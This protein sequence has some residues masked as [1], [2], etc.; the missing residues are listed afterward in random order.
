MSRRPALVTLVGSA[1]LVSLGCSAATTTFSSLSNQGIVPVSSENPFMGSNLFLA[2]EM[3]ES[4]YLYNFLK[5]RGA[6]Q[7][8]ALQGEKEEE[9]QMTMYYSGTHESYSATP[10]I[11]PTL[12]NREWII[13]GPYAL[14]RSVYREVSQL[15][16]SDGAVFEIFGRREVL[17]GPVRAAET[18]VIAPAFVPTPKPKLHR[19]KRK[20]KTEQPATTE[21]TTTASSGDAPSNFDQEALAEARAKGQGSSSSA[22]PNANSAP[23]A[24]RAKATA[25]PLVVFERIKPQVLPGA[26][27]S[28][29]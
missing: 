11:D 22:T 17:G 27:P 10:Q 12:R 20:A 19:K 16:P 4:S 2:K 14:D 28:T 21:S 29:R 24:P 7:A 6:P 15:P 26:T 25:G 8:I 1:L 23:K 9:A 5:E 3:E 13:R 18:R